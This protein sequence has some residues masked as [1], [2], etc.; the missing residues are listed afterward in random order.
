MSLA[1]NRQSKDFINFYDDL[2][3]WY[4]AKK[5]NLDSN[6]RYKWND[7]NKFIGDRKKY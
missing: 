3:L 6:K 7:K 4:Y 5:K 1:G 2:V